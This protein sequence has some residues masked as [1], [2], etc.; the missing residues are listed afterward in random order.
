MFWSDNNYITSDKY[1]D[2]IREYLENS[3]LNS[4]DYQIDNKSDLINKAAKYTYANALKKSFKIFIND[5][6]NWVRGKQ[7]KDSYYYL[8]WVPSLFRRVSN[9]NYVLSRSVKPENLDEYKVV[10]FTLHLEPEIALQYFSPEFSNSMEAIIWISKS[11]PADYILVVKEQVNSYGIRS[12]WYYKQFIQM[13][14]VLLSHPEVHSWDWIN[15]SDIVATITG[16]VGQEAIH[17]SKPVLSFGK[18]QVINH[19]PTV[20]YV[21][22]YVE[23][24]KSIYNII[25]HYPTVEDFNCAKNSFVNAQIDLS[26]DIPKYKYILRSVSLESDIASKALINLFEEYPDLI[27]L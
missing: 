22:N 9:Y 21:S 14:N 18:H 13:P 8:G 6:K 25:N 10:F 23:T 4:I 15:K 24:K 3:E 19:L 2:K 7:K 16:T 17:F 26:I 20:H 1:I 11:L 12:N 5:T 27:G